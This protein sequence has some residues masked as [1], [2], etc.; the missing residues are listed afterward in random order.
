MPIIKK[1]LT[2]TGIADIK[3]TTAGQ[4]E[5]QDT[6]NSELRMTVGKDT[7]AFIVKSSYK[8][9]PRYT[10]LGHFPAMLPDEALELARA[11]RSHFSKHGT[12][13]DAKREEATLRNALASRERQMNRKEMRERSIRQSNNTIN[14]YFS[15]WF[16]IPLASI[17]RPM[18]EDRYE[19]IYSKKGLPRGVG[20]KQRGTQPTA[21]AAKQAIKYL[22][23]AYSRALIDYPNAGL[24]PAI[25]YKFEFHDTTPKK[26]EYPA[27]PEGL[28]AIWDAIL[29]RNDR[30]SSVFFAIKLYTGLRI[31]SLTNVKWSDVDLDNAI[32]TIRESKRREV[33]KLPLS[34]QLVE[35]FKLLPRTSSEW[36]F[37]SPN[38]ASG[39]AENKTATWLPCTI[40]DMRRIWRTVAK[41]AG[42]SD[43]HVRLLGHWKTDEEGN[44]PEQSE[45]YLLQMWTFIAPDQQ[46]ISDKLDELIAGQPLTSMQ[47][48]ADGF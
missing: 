39:H 42:V 40:H 24:N 17:T 27:T 4:Q 37:P 34:R 5:Y 13:P 35:F 28:A 12:W 41:L 45:A 26:R 30:L 14:L 32:L 3:F 7:K 22:Q 15:D 31:P 48:I 43:H 1:R 9:L 19:A 18:L 10:T 36:C 20:P 21:S 47:V 33:F 6:V 44:A 46:R 11:Y 8:G 25:F 2:K 16:D 29:K 38:S 23:A